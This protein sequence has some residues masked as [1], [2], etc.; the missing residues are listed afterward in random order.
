MKRNKFS[1]SH[2]KLMT[3]DMGKLYP[4]SWYEILPGDTIQQRTQML[5]RLSPLL[6]PVMHPVRIRVNSFF[7][8]Y[9]LIWSDFEDFITGG[10]DGND[11]TVPPKMSTPGSTQGNLGDYLGVPPGTYTGNIE[12]SALPTRAYRL[13]WNEYFRD[14]DL[15]TEDTIDLGNGTDS[16]T[17]KNTINQV[18]WEKD[19]FTCARP[20]EQKGTEITIP[21]V[22]NAP[23]TGIGT[24]SQ[25]FS[26]SSGTAYETD[27]TSPTYAS[28]VRSDNAS[29]YLMA[30]EGATGYPNIY[31][32]LSAATGLS[33][34][35]LRLYLAMQRYQENRAEFGSRYVE[36]LASLG[37]RSSD[38]RLNNPEFLSGARQTISFSEILS[39]DGANTGDMKGHGIAALR[40][41]RFRRFFEEHGIV[42]TL[43][44]VVPKAIYA[45]GVQR[46]FLKTT[47]EDYYQ[48]ELALIG[49]QEIQN[50]ETYAE[51]STP[52]G[53]FGYQQ[54]YDEYRYIPSGIAGEFRSTLN[55]WHYARIFGSDTTL[56]SS[57]ISCDPTKR[58]YADNNSDVL[59][60]M[61]NHSVQARRMIP[62]YPRKRVM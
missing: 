33:I 34:N 19:Y 26:Q 22:G 10:P 50:R 18:A 30:E 49:D 61:A 58:Q 8:P 44:S 12:Y 62:K 4:I 17:D 39:T 29:E 52:A 56:N 53:V 41:N 38:A 14:Q 43:M 46:S 40:S 23:V 21:L 24:N 59:Y 27:G 54:R 60:V 42:M 57:F 13:I 5:V 32:D 7:V 55:H 9:R 36:Y 20:W 11:N 35:D 31:A 47:K 2:Y 28:Y 48:R 1:L 16:T 15:M 51:H 25:G 6:S 45:S 37:V 3:A